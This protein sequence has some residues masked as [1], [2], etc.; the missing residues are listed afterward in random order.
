[1]WRKQKTAEIVVGVYPPS[2]LGSLNA[3]LSFDS[4]ADLMT[5]TPTVLL[6]IKFQES[7][8]PNHRRRTVQAT[9]S[10]EAAGE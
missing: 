9:M 5:A 7:K 2:G 1:M 6:V 4:R 3:K 10:P 8:T